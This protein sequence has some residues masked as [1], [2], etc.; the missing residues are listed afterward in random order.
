[1]WAVS[2]INKM[3][4]FVNSSYKLNANVVLL[5]SL[6]EPCN[7]DFEYMHNFTEENRVSAVNTSSMYVTMTRATVLLLCTIELYCLLA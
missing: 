1:M 7:E 5:L 2:L 3:L 6:A 4:Y